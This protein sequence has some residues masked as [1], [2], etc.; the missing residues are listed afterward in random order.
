[1]NQEGL[2]IRLAKLAPPSR[3]DA[4]LDVSEDKAAYRFPV[5]LGVGAV[6]PREPQPTS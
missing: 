3:F 4:S 1:M 6:R 5:S 2:A